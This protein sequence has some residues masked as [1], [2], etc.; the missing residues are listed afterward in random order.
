MHTLAGEPIQVYLGQ[1]QDHAVRRLAHKA[2]ISVAEVILRCL[3]RYI[4]DEL[5]IEQDPAMSIVA[6]G[7]SDKG[8]LSERHD[9]Y[10]TELL[11]EQSNR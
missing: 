1:E 4:E 7:C 9:H 6:L 10:I 2:G 5:T 3:E 8:D 11:R